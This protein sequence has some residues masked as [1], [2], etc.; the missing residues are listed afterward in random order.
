MAPSPSSM[1]P[2][3]NHGHLATAETAPCLLMISLCSSLTTSELKDIS[4]SHF[5]ED[6]AK[7]DKSLQCRFEADWRIT[8]FFLRFNWWCSL[9]CSATVDLMHITPC[10]LILEK[11]AVS[12]MWLCRS[13]VSSDSVLFIQ[14]FGHPAFNDIMLT[15]C[16]AASSRLLHVETVAGR[17]CW[18]KQLVLV[19]TLNHCAGRNMKID[20]NLLK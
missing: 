12:Q 14:T 3:P 5:P 17:P 1:Q 20:A 13:F 11:I 18:C 2:H 10:F 6:F 8:H 9:N 16:V 19:V 4:L 7:I 15:V